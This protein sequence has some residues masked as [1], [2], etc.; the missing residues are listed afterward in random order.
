MPS[1]DFLNHTQNSHLALQTLSNKTAEILYMCGFVLEDVY[2]C[3]RFDTSLQKWIEIETELK[4]DNS[5]PV[6]VS[7]LL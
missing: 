6:K 5:D 2:K 7:L 1:F 3:F 4:L